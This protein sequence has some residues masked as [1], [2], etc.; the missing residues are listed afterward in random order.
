MQDGL[1]REGCIR[2]L[3]P[4]RLIGFSDSN[5]MCA[6]KMARSGPAEKSRGLLLTGGNILQRKSLLALT[7]V[8]PVAAASS[9]DL[10]CA[11]LD[12]ADQDS[13]RR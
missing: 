1:Q 8:M 3:S 5:V 4:C 13:D 7:A 12:E 10:R 2:Q 9:Q 11:S 6:A